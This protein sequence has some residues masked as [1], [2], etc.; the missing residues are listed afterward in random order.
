MTLDL[1][2]PSRNTTLPTTVWPWLYSRPAPVSTQ[3]FY[4]FANDDYLRTVVDV[5]TN[6]IEHY[7]NDRV[8]IRDQFRYGSATAAASG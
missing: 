4:G 7:Y 1:S 5:G 3:H 2:A 6:T 8:S